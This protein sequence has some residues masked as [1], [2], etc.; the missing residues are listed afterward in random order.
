VLMLVFFIALVLAA[1]ERGW[2][3]VSK[4]AENRL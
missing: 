2:K 4:V 1:S 3:G